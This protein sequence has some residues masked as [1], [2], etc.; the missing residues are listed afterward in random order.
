MYI[1]SIFLVIAICWCTLS[2][3]LPSDRQQPIKIESDRAEQNEKKGTTT[4]EGSVIIRQGTIKINADKVT[5]FSDANKVDRIVCEGKPAHY[6]QRRNPQDG[7]VLASASTIKYF[8]VN[9]KIALIKNA[10]LEQKGTVI[11][12]E[13]IDYDLKAEVVKATAGRNTKERIQMVIPPSNQ[14]DT[15]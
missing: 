13:Q 6:Q 1:K 11:T 7:L 14:K 10:S 12:G 8:L 5:V 9:D 15:E 2:N 4:Y 3:A